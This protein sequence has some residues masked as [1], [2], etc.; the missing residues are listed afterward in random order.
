MPSQ[1]ITEFIIPLMWPSACDAGEGG[2]NATI[3]SIMLWSL[4]GR[5]VVERE[6][7]GRGSGF[8]L[9]THSAQLNCRCVRLEWS[10][11]NAL[12]YHCICPVVCLS[13]IFHGYCDLFEEK[14]RV[15]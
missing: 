9:A 15:I 11:A 8:R 4:R 7:S 10:L 2:N 3:Y 13:F 6:L 5:C 1:V 14:E 12:G